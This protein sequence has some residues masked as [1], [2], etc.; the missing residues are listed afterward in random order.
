MTYTADKPAA[1]RVQRRA[2]RPHP[3]LGRRPRPGG[4]PVGARSERFDPA[5]PARTGTSPS[6]SPRAAARERSVEHAFLTPGLRHG[7]SRSKGVSGAIRRLAYARY[8]E[9]RA[10]HWLLLIAADRVDAWESHVRSFATLRPD[11]PVTQT[12]VLSERRRHGIASRRGRGAPTACTSPRPPRR[13]RPVGA[14]RLGRDQGSAGAGADRS[15]PL[16]P[17]GRE[18]CVTPV[19]R[20]TGVTHVRWRRGK[21]QA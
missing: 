3:R 17:P 2:A 15:P 9:G 7:R 6:G 20:T 14:R 19:A 16:T 18:R 5:R 10:A 13:R 1:A 21:G 8:S 11:N 12:G 4:P